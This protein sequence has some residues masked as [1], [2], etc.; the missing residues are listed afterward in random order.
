MVGGPVGAPVFWTFVWIGILLVTFVPLAL[1]G[2]S[3]RT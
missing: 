2:Y 1:R 3:R